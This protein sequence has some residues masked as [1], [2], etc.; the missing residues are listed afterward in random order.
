MLGTLR[1]MTEQQLATELAFFDA[2]NGKLVKLEC[3]ETIQRNNRVRVN[4]LKWEIIRRNVSS[5]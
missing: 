5:P 4:A 2:M 3:S 1:E